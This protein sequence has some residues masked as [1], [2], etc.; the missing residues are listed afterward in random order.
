[1][2]GQRAFLFA[3]WRVA[4]ATAG[5]SHYGHTF[6]GPH[7]RAG[8]SREECGGILIHLLHRLNLDDPAIPFT[9]PGIQWLPLYYFER[10]ETEEEFDKS[11]HSLTH[12]YRMK[13]P[14]S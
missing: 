3:D 7:D 11:F 8:A 10:P 4:T 5:R 14:R 12:I 6:G 1:V 13:S 9:V 2:F